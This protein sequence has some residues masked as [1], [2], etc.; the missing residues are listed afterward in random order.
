MSRS[1]DFSGGEDRTTRRL[2]GIGTL[3][4]VPAAVTGA[5]D[6]L[7]TSGP[8]RRVG[9]VH[10]LA[11]YGG[12]GFQA[13]SWWARRTGSRRRG[14]ALSLAG[15]TFTAVGGWLG[16]H[17]AYA[18]GVGVDTTAFQHLPSDWTDVADAA[19]V[20]ERPIGREADGV[21]VFLVRYQTRIVALADRCT[22]RGG[23]LHEGEFADGCITCPWHGSVFDTDGTV[24]SG[25]ATRP[26]AVLEVRVVDGRVQVRRDE[27]RTL[28]TN[29]VGH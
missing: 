11:N 4:A 10:A 14:I 5:S 15:M 13:A 21:S 25:P 12:I 19:E 24:R 6:W 3:G 9:L 1:T 28:R 29:P 7:T 27:Q 18:L 20:T 26:E 23:P 8:E 16:A 2:I 22:H 17:L